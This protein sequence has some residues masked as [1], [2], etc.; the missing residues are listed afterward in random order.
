MSSTPLSGTVLAVCVS[1]GGIPTR[2]VDAARVGSLGLEGD[3]QRQSFHGGKG[4][5][6]CLLSVEEVR[7]LCADGVHDAGPGTFGENLRTEGVDFAALA[8]GDRLAIGDEVV[9][10][11][12]DVREPCGTLKPL[13]ARFPDLMVGRS[14]LLC[15]VVRGGEVRRGHSIARSDED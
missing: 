10:E 15:S 4:R 3:V 1:P 7:S 11:V 8:P 9:L 2:E 14:G 12:H 6:V 13:D 5:A